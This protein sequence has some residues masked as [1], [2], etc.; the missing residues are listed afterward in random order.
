[1]K[2]KC[3]RNEDAS[4]GADTTPVFR[5][6]LFWPQVVPS[7]LQT[8]LHVILQAYPD[9][10]LQF[11]TTLCSFK[12]LHNTLLWLS[13]ST[14]R[15]SVSPIAIHLLRPWDCWC[16]HPM[17]CCK[18]GLAVD[19]GLLT[20]MGRGP[21]L[22]QWKWHMMEQCHHIWTFVRKD[23]ATFDSSAVSALKRQDHISPSSW[24]SPSLPQLP[25]APT[26]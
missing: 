23:L 7:F 22:L 1:M 10:I 8:K 3:W 13:S 14:W 20:G 4:V 2:S 26:A 17:S 6:D 11:F 15:R 21:W 5:M 18:L 19:W 9:K 16:C 12:T 25:I 24:K